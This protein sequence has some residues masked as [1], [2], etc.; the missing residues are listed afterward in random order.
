MERVSLDADG[1]QASGDSGGAAISSGGE[2]VTFSST[3][4]LTPDDTNGFWDRYMRDRDAGATLRT[5]DGGVVGWPADVS[6]DGRFV[7]NG[8]G[9]IQVL[10]RLL[11]TLTRADV[12][13]DGSEPM[14]AGTNPSMSDGG[15]Y[16]AFD[17]L[18]GDLVPD[19]TNGVADVFVRDLG[20]PASAV[21]SDPVADAGPDLEATA[22]GFT[23]TVQLDG[24]LS[25]DPDGD[26]LSYSWSGPFGTAGGAGPE[27]MLGIGSHTVELEVSDDS[28]A[29]DTDE[30][31]VTVVPEIGW[32]FGDD[33]ETGG[34]STWSTAVP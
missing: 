29:T 25:F 4:H 6:T 12:K 33:F 24:R 5:S 15:R 30:L 20:L 8:E 27:V 1:F 16:V 18:Y 2:F 31:T 32:I 21:N 7:L 23:A 28:A 11:D 9:G 26:P 3:A 22:I 19:D 17:Y 10:D 13:P 14:Y 34:T